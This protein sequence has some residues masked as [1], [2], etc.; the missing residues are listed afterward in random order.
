MSVKVRRCATG[1]VGS[2]GSVLGPYKEVIA[3]RLEEYPE[4]S[5]VRLFREVR[6]L[7]YPG[8]YDQVKRHVLLVRPRPE[9]E[10]AVRFETD[11]GRQG[12]VDF[13]S[14]GLPWGRRQVL[15]VVLGYSRMLW[16][17]SYPRQTMGVLLRGLEAAFAYF[18]GVPEE[19]L[20]DQMKSVVLED[21]RG[22]GGGVLRNQEFAR[23]ARHWDFRVKV[24]R[25]YRAQTKGKVERPISYIRRG[26]FY[27]REFV[28]DEDVNV[29]AL[30]WLER[31]ANVRVH[32]TLKERPLDRF[33]RERVVLGPLAP[34]PYPGVAGLAAARRV[35]A[36][37]DA[38]SAEKTGLS[39][40]VA[41]RP[42]AEYARLSGGVG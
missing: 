42:L 20:F 33:E 37:S 30:R 9:V 31:E 6:E 16:F 10:P 22:S 13:A 36:G 29:Q 38:A 35:R 21:R 24:C 1:R 28:S 2:V 18:G 26:F 5:A 3:A 17:Q 25:P 8:G 41:R 32:G 11:P 40:P 27:G 39:I 12:Q 19:L 14:V 15:V 4:L 34:G 23:F 7:G